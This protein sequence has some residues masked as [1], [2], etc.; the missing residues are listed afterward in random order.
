MIVSNIQRA[1]LKLS[2]DASIM[3]MQIRD[4][5]NPTIISLEKLHLE[6]YLVQQNE[7]PLGVIGCKDI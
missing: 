6:Q 2:M 1:V 3:V 4:H 7:L 5:L